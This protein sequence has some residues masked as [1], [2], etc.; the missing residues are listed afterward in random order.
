MKR[1]KATLV[2]S[3]KRRSGQDIKA[4]ELL[5]SEEGMREITLFHLQ[6]ALEKAL[7]AYLIWCEVNFPHTHDLE[8]LLDIARRK[9]ADFEQLESAAGLT[10]FAIAGKYPESDQWIDDCDTEEWLAT[11]RHAC[12]FIWGKI[13]DEK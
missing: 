12:D 11:T 9:D 13:R 6:Q 7:K 10:D 1:N 3:W 2:A 5:N 4:A 8:L